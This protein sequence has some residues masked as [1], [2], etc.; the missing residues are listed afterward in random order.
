MQ[1]KP[2]VKLEEWAVVTTSDEFTPPEMQSIS[3]NGKV[4]GHPRFQDGEIVTTSSIHNV[5]GKRVATQ[6][7]IYELGEPCK[8][9][10]KWM[11]EAGIKFNPEAPF[12][13]RF[14]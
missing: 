4:Y 10:L 3:L 8:D 12:G 5:K 9:W 1:V 13:E 2:V 7:T 6:N 11:E 14:K